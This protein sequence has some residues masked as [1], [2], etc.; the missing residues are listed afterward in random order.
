MILKKNVLAGVVVIG[1]VVAGLMIW[2]I[3][4]RKR[5]KEE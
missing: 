2:L 4:K 3:I 1:L 5:R